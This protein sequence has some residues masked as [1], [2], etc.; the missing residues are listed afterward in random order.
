[1]SQVKKLG[2]IDWSGIIAQNDMLEHEFL[3]LTI[4]AGSFGSTPN[5][6]R[7]IMAQCYFY[8]TASGAPNFQ[9]RLRIGQS[10]LAF[11][12]LNPILATQ[13]FLIQTG[14]FV[15]I[16]ARIVSTE[17]VAGDATTRIWTYVE[18]ES[19]P[20][21]LGTGDGTVV[22]QPMTFSSVFFSTYGRTVD[23]TIALDL[24]VTGQWSAAPGGGQGVQGWAYKLELFEP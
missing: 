6:N 15:P 12:S 10:G 24:V 23:A 4:P 14:Q 2:Y 9:A 13:P 7:Q 20:N 19:R 1:M 8:G 17:E 16:R 5:R 18:E 21:F 22:G 11:G 3:R